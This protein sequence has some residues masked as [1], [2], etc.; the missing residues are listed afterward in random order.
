MGQES[1]ASHPI[2]Y[3]SVVMNPKN[4]DEERNDLDLMSYQV[5]KKHKPI[6]FRINEDSDDTD[7]GMEED[8]GEAQ[9]AQFYVRHQSGHPIQ[10]IPASQVA[11]YIP[12]IPLSTLMAQQSRFQPIWTPPELITRI[13]GAA[14]EKPKRKSYVYRIKEWIILIDLINPSS[15]LGLW[16]LQTRKKYSGLSL[17]NFLYVLLLIIPNFFAFKRV[18]LTYTL[19]LLYKSV[20]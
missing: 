7:T 3:K 16:S 17:I 2:S 18:T 20:K 9:Q 10:L 8:E 5:F 14:R 12:T 11:D 13:P 19:Y 6:S 15:Y 4:V 1:S